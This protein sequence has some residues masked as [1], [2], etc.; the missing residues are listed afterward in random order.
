MKAC[1]AKKDKSKNTS[2]DVNINIIYPLINEYLKLI[3]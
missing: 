3:N 1:K 2:K